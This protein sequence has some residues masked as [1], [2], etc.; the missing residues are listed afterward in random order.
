MKFVKTSQIISTSVVD[1]KLA[2][3]VQKQLNWNE[4]FYTLNCQSRRLH[5]CSSPTLLHGI[6]PL[7]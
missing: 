3:E 2:S 6:Q 1:E 7:L 5:L 4:P